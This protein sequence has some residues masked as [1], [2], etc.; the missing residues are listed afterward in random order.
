MKCLLR[1][2]V[3]ASLTANLV[4][5][6]STS[7]ENKVTLTSHAELTVPAGRVWKIEN[8]PAWK[9]EF[10][11]GDSDLY[12]DG[13]VLMGPSQGLSM[14]G[15]IE[16]TSTQKQAFPIWLRGGTK[17]RIGNS[18]LSIEV[19][20]SFIEPWLKP[21]PTLDSLGALSRH[22]GEYPCS[23]GL[24]GAPVLQSA[25]RE[26]LADDYGAYLEHI[27]VAGCGAIARRGG[28]FLLDVSQ[29]HVGGDT[30]MILVNPATSKVWLF[31]MPASVSAKKWKL[32]SG[33]QVPTEVSSIVV[34]ELNTGWGH[35]ANFAWID[36]QLVIRLR[37]DLQVN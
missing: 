23:T 32:N 18:R 24:L 6:S 31:W 34:D 10:G 16:L 21:L 27:D 11:I 2:G 17:V 1:I 15:R 12:L 8:A 20:E 4:A 29:T 19:T 5:Q 37:E 22:V 25:I 14:N 36:G 33:S 35:V 28:W 26:I 7:V 3:A 30:S 9:S 13:S